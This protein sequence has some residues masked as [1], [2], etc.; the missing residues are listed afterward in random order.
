M[1]E[2]TVFA[3]AIG[4]KASHGNLLFRICLSGSPI[5]NFKNINFLSKS[6]GCHDKDSY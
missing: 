6:L 5:E 4:V 1:T 3:A 2:D